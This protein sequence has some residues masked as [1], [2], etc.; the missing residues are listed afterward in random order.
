MTSTIP[1]DLS[2]YYKT[3]LVGTTFMILPRR[4]H[5]LTPVLSRSFDVRVD[6]I[7]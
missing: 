4:L 5:L 3:G 1:S 6:G 2:E 7:D